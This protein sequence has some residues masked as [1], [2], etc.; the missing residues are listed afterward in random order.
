M[1]ERDGTRVDVHVKVLDERVVERAKARGIDVLVYAPHFTRL[2][3]IRRRAEA[4]S[5]DEL[6]V[7]PAREVFT[8]TWRERK[9]VLA[10]GLSEPVPDFVSLDAAMAEFERQ[11]AAV[12]VPHPE[13]LSVG[14]AEA[15]VR[16]HRDVVDAVEV[17]NP[18]HWPRHTR[19]A[20]EIAD[21]V[22][23]PATASSYAHL[24]RSVGG[25]WTT[26][27]REID[28]EADLVAALR[29]GAPRQACRRADDEHRL[30]SIAEFSHLAWENSWKKFDRIVLSGREP[31]HPER[32]AYDERFDEASVY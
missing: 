18:K 17:Y 4:Y 20:R 30:E 14:L 2:P 24:R 23:A 31:T 1:S 16:R 6:L 19:R 9:H 21:A 3:E 5:D 7:V 15:D 10:V 29:D 8:G 27:D 22:D 13:F 11:D 32:D 25:A 28:S 26:F 12:V